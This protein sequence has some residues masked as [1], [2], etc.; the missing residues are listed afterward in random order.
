MKP[1][2]AT[3]RRYYDSISDPRTI[4]TVGAGA[5]GC[6]KT[7]IAC[8]AAMRL[9]KSRQVAK[10]V[11]TR[12][13]VC[14]DEQHGFLP[15]DISG[16]MQPYIQPIYDCIRESVTKPQLAKYIDDGVIEIAPLAY[17]RGRTFNDAL[18]I[19]DEAQNTTV[20]QMKMLLTRV[21]A[22]ASIVITGDPSQSDLGAGT[23]NGLNDLLTRVERS[24]EL[25]DECVIDV[26]SFSVETDMLR[27]DAI[28]RILEMYA[29]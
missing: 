23:V 1:Y 9:L 24:F 22:R 19:V 3:H 5:A 2:T 11:I 16:K 20:S 25:N 15:G 17:M 27:N 14:V 28:E 7:H 26:V 12:P 21:G 18:V 4:I 8:T 13:A 29:R 6:G 10:V